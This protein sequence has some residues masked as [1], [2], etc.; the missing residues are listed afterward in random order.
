[1]K[2][3]ILITMPKFPFPETGA[4]EKDRAEGIRI[5]I[6]LGYDIR[7]ITKVFDGQMEKVRDV[8]ENLGIRIIP[9]TYKNRRNFMRFLNPISWDGASYEYRDKEIQHIFERE[10]DDFKPDVVWFE[11]SN[12]WPL[13]K[14]AKKRGSKIITRSHNFE[15]IHFLEEEGFSILNI[16]KFFSKLAGEL[17]MAK[18]SDLIFA[19]TPKEEKIYKKLGA[20]MVAVLPLR[21]LSKI[22]KDRKEIK[23]KEV[24]DIFFMGSTYNVPHNKRSA[25]FL[26]KDVFPKVKKKLPGKFKLH[27]LGKKLPGDLDRYLDGDIIY[28]GYIEIEDLDIFLGNM[29]IA[30][31]PSLAGAG[32]QQK[33]F[34]PLARGIPTV[35]SKRGLAGYPFEDGEHI[36][37]A[38][39]ADE[40]SDALLKLRD[41]TL[42]SKLSKNAIKISASFFSHDVMENIILKNINV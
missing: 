9:V 22:I 25:E 17:V 35:T 8:S 41:H 20:K 24:L 3:K 1:M 5:F 36:L 31:V 32:M 13:Y 33:I 40:F 19:I 23:E 30:V 14:H 10:L 37:A 6:S 2:K 12:L 28:E 16:F 21:G 39:S 7:V 11:Y 38:D 18:K 29:D 34:E 27:I 42:R 4:C 15:P 26:L